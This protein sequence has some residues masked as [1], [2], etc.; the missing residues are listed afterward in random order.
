MI[1]GSP[2]KISASSFY[3][4][5]KCP[6]LV[7]LDLYGDP[8]KRDPYSE[9]MQ[10]LWERGVQTEKE[11]IDKIKVGV[12]VATVA[13]IA[14]QQTFEK[15]F[16][17]MKQGAPL[18]YQGVLVSDD[19]IGRPD[20]LE[21]ISG[22]SKLGSYHYMPCDIKSG[23]AFAEKGGEDIK[24]HYADQVVFYGE[25]LSQIQ[26]KGPDQGKIIDVEGTETSFVL[27]DY[28]DNYEANKA[29]I[30]SIVYDKREDEPLIGG[31]CKN[32]AWCTHCVAWAYENK[33]LT[34]VFKLGKQKYDLRQRGIKTLEDLNK[35]NVSDYLRPPLKITRVG[36]STLQ[37]WKRRA[38]VWLSGKPIVYN[39]P[40][41]RPAKLEVYYDIEDDPSIDHVYLHGFIEVRN[42]KKG[43]YKSIEAFS[44]HDEER[45]AHELWNYID[46]LPD[47]SVIYHYGSYEKTKMNRLML[48]Y[49]LPQHVMDKF[50]KLRVDLYREL[51]KGSDWPLWSYG[52]KSVAKFL[53]FAW[54]AE[55]ASGANSV[56][57]YNDYRK[58][59]EGNRAL[60]E[61]I[62][63]YNKE[64]CDAMV[65]VKEW[66]GK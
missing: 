52:V 61:K 62:L 58:D 10:L 3:N 50:E 4:F 16:A 12:E 56:A 11:I 42:G 35:I 66:L 59:P 33:D 13:G 14:N 9:F 49:S 53:G 51:E 30:H 43:L 46:S 54:T 24:S 34:L 6:R 17:L 27:S 40:N 37:N 65:V 41:F 28:K 5:T 38:G 22:S 23:R 57:W 44:K 39:K 36:E 25:L 64:D 26:D 47:D 60:L 63:T 55:D 31:D 15:T 29:D 2:Y 1:Q 48:K 20:L 18:I 45:S 7:Y 8:S 19:K 21:K 32:C